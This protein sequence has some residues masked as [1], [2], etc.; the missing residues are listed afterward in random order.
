MAQSSDDG[1]S[2]RPRDA[3]GDTDGDY[4]LGGD[5]DEG[6]EGGTS[7]PSD[8]HLT[9]AYTHGHEEQGHEWVCDQVIEVD[10][11]VYAVCCLDGACVRLEEP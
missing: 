8:A 11:A 6:F 5:F 9:H 7:S 1:D 2:G 10:G 4:A 3:E